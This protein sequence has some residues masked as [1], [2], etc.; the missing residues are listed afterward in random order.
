M[1]NIIEQL[2]NLLRSNEPAKFKELIIGHPECNLDVLYDSDTLLYYAVHYAHV[3][4]GMFD[5][6]KILVD[7]G[8][9]INIKNQKIQSGRN[10]LFGAVQ[11]CLIFATR[12]NTSGEKLAFDGTNKYYQIIKYLLESGRAD[13]NTTDNSGLTPLMSICLHTFD[14]RIMPIMKDVITLLLDHGADRDY[15][16]DHDLY[17]DET[18][19]QLARNGEN[20][21]MADYIRDYQPMATKGCH[22]DGI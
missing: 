1:A 9:S 12:I 21:E 22:D 10:V 14:P 19:E 6:V 11:Q 4:N 7:H 20:I 3:Y 13:P 5:F 17:H 16:N 18:A 15:V 8:A 2:Y